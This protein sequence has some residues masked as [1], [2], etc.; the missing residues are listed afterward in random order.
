MAIV[1]HIP[2]AIPDHLIHELPISH[3]IAKARP[4]DQVGSSTHTLHPTGYD[5]VRITQ[6]DGLGR[7]YDRFQAAATHLVDRQCRNFHG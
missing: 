5:N 2:Q 3:A 4:L 6:L 1:K 7:Q